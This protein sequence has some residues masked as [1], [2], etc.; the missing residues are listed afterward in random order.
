MAALQRRDPAARFELFTSVPRW[1]FEQSLVQ[2]FGYHELAS[3]IGLAQRNSLHEDIPETVRRLDAFVPF[4]PALVDALAR[5]VVALGCGQVVCDIAPLGIAVARAAGLSNTLI[6]NFT[7]DW[8][9][10]GYAEQSP[11]L[12][13]HIETLRSVFASADRR[14]QTEPVCAYQRN[15]LLAAPVSRAPRTAPDETRAKLGIPA[16]APLVLITMGGLSSADQHAFLD[17]LACWPQYRFVIP[18]SSD[19]PATTGN[20]LRLPNHSALYHPDI[21]R[22][23]DAVVGKTGYSTVAEAYHAGLPYGYVSRPRFRESAVMDAYIQAH[24]R[25]IAFSESEFRSGAW[26]NR[27]PDLLA[28]GRIERAEPNGAEQVAEFLIAQ[29]RFR[30][31]RESGHPAQPPNE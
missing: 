12:R 9:Y 19:A 3:D 10:E 20:V 6:E 27:L 17:Q 24:M 7:W 16:G 29:G 5:Q 13:P 1:L 18:G 11:E 31:V 25:G 22:A 15:D 21:M 30:H 23:A 28:L 4:R 14:V 26:L 8:I 2:P